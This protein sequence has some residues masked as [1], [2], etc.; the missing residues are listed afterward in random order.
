MDKSSDSFEKHGSILKI[1]LHHAVDSGWFNGIG[2]VILV[3]DKVK[4][5]EPLTL[6]IPS[7]EQGHYLYI[8][9]SNMKSICN[10]CHV[11]DHTRVSCPVLLRRRKAYFICESTQHL[12]S[13]YPDAPWNPKRK[14]VATYRSRLMNTNIELTNTEKEAL[15][16]NSP[17]EMDTEMSAEDNSS[18]DEE[19]I[20]RSNL[21]T[22]NNED[23]SHKKPDRKEVTKRLLHPLVT[24]N[25]LSMNIRKRN[26]S[27]A[28]T[29]TSAAERAKKKS[30]LFD[31]SL[32][33]EDVAFEDEYDRNNFVPEGSSQPS[34]NPTYS[35]YESS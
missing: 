34:T 16:L 35:H 19:N 5:Y 15:L 33:V 27:E 22:Q 13:Q 4:N 7:W 12:K 26:N 30:A 23:S 20:D 6:Q 31:D 8:V 21:S 1:G 24:F 11:D 18:V 3:K 2:Y 29:P 28:F 32:E 25:S 14:Q 9:W 17:Q 10:P